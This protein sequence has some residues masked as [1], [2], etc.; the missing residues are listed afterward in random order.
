MMAKIFVRSDGSIEGVYSEVFVPIIASS[1]EVSVER[2]SRVEFNPELK[3][4]EVILPDGTVIHRNISRKEAI[5][6][7]VAFFENR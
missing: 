2:L 1:A 6:F 7:E 4:W 5:K 3:L